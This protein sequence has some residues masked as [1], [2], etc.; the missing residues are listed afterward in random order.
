M[1]FAQSGVVLGAQRGADFFYLWMEDRPMP[2][3]QYAMA[4][5]M[6]VGILVVCLFPLAPYWLRISVVYFFLGLLAF[7]FALILVRFLI[8]L[9]VFAFTGACLLTQQTTFLKIDMARSNL[10]I[11]RTCV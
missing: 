5:L 2:P 3:W 8:F 10:T 4:V 6:V 11:F 9:T 1:T 7:I